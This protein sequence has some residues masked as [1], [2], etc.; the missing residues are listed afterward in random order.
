MG[1]A[2]RGY[3]GGVG[4]GKGMGKWCNSVSI[5]KQIKRI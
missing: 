3:V 5:K 4:G 1:T 2:G